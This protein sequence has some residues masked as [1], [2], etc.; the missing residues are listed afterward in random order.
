MIYT[1]EYLENLADNINLKVIA[2]TF[3]P[4]W[5]LAMREFVTK[6]LTHG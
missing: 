5:E 1:R 4:I 2:T 3:L 6:C